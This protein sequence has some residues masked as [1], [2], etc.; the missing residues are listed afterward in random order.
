MQQ[1]VRGGE[2]WLVGRVTSSLTARV[3]ERCFDCWGGERDLF[4]WTLTGFQ[5]CS[6]PVKPGETDATQP[7]P[8][9]LAL[10]AEGSMYL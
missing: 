8:V 5:T 7:P 4:Q 9:I 1:E 2:R 3:K 6:K 10:T